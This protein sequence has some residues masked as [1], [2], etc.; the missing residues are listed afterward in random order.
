MSVHPAIASAQAL[1]VPSRIAE[2]TLA[3]RPVDCTGAPVV[4]SRAA[5]RTCA[6]RAPTDPRGTTHGTG[7]GA[8][9]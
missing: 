3:A 5:N 9:S 6:G 2:T 7:S 1:T 8:Y 4:K